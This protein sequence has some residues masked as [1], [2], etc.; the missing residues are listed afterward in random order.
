MMMSEKSYKIQS[1]VLLRILRTSI[2]IVRAQ[3]FKACARFFYQILFFT[4]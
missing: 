1:S 3:L 2:L 4:K